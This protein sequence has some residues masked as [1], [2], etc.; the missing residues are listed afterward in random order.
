MNFTQYEVPYPIDQDYSKRIAYFS[1]EFAVHQ[2]LN[3]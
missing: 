3:I 1:M 2:P